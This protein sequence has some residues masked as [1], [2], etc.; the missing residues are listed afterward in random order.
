MLGGD[1]RPQ[2]IDGSIFFDAGTRAGVDAHI[3][4]FCEAAAERVR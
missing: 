1:G 4:E 3:V 2:R